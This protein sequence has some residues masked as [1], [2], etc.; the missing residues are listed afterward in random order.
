MHGVISLPDMT[1]YDKVS[2][3]ILEKPGIAATLVYKDDKSPDLKVNDKQLQT[4]KQIY[5][6]ID[7]FIHNTT[8]ASWDDGYS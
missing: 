4:A 8:A 6:Y 1:L 5:I 2:S 3:R 7:W